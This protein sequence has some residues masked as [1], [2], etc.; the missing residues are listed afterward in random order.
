M[1]IKRKPPTQK[2]AKY[3]IVTNIRMLSPKKSVHNIIGQRKS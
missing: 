3:N 2:K 1:V